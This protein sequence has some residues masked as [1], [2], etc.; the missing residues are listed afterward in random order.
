ML[1]KLKVEDF[2]CIDSQEFELKKLTI[3]T[4]L[5]SSGKSSVLQAILLLSKHYSQSNQNKAVFLA[6]HFSNFNEIRNK[7]KNARSLTISAESTSN[8]FSLTMLADLSVSLVEANNETGLDCDDNL[9]YI[10]ANRIGQEQFS[11][12]NKNQ[13]IGIN[14]EYIFGYFHDRK[15]D[16]IENSLVKFEQNNTLK[17]Q[18]NE[19]LKYI[20]DL[21][22]SLNT[23]NVSTEMVKI[24]FDSDGLSNINPFNL[25]AGTSYLVKILIVSLMCKKEDLLLIENPEIHLHPKAQS[26]LG[27]FFAWVSKAG[28]QLIVETHSEHLI[29]KIKYQIYNESL[30]PTDAVVYYKPSIEGDFIRLNIN[31]NGRF[32]NVNGDNTIFPSGFFDSTLKELLEIG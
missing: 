28:I 32:V 2:K 10:S 6:S 18:V 23:E 31:Q 26:R 24:S 27:E 7:Y 5:N 9:Y 20:L 22:I 11:S 15:D 4:G 1:N 14:G 12:F 17:V 25:G 21:P 8:K 29:N 13:K 16:V 3:L 19:W 30:D